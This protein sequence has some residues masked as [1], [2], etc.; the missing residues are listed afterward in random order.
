MIVLY[1]LTIMLWDRT[2][3][4]LPDKILDSKLHEFGGCNLGTKSKISVAKQKI[5]GQSQLLI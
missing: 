5:N 2:T 4:D 3:P 1:K